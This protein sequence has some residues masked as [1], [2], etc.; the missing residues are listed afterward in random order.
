MSYEMICYYMVQIYFSTF[1]VSLC[2]VPVL[3]WR[4]NYD[5]LAPSI[6][7]AFYSFISMGF[8]WK[9]W[10]RV[11]SILYEIPWVG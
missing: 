1:V 11:F 6:V 9:I 5:L 2:M 10:F 4:R 3:L 7:L 8:G